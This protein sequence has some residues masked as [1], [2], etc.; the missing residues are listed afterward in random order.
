MYAN[1]THSYSQGHT[2]L[3]MNGLAASPGQP[4]PFSVTS[5]SQTYVIN[6]SQ[7]LL[8]RTMLPISG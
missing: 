7:H 3:S 4:Q 2:P 1:H 5:S 6:P 8:P